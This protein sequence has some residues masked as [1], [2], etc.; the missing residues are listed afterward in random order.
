MV[1]FNRLAL[2]LPLPEARQ[3][4]RGRAPLAQGFFSRSRMRMPHADYNLTP[5]DPRDLAEAVAFA[6]RFF[7]GRTRKHDADAFWAAIAAER[8]VRH[9]DRARFV[10]MKRPPT[11]GGAAQSM[12]RPF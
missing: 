4:P 10:V 3:S 5:A 9:L 7:E 11:G 2:I 1:V 12:D 6:L 8:V